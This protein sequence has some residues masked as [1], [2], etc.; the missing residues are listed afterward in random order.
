[1]R[2]VTRWMEDHGLDLAMEKTELLLVTKK[3]IT[4][5]VPKQVGTE[6][7]RTKPVVKHFGLKIVRKLNY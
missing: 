4:T 7:M 2:R 6:E 1:M 5:V 3:Q